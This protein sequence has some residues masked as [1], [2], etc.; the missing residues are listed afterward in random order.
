[1][2][3]AGVTMRTFG[4]ETH[5]GPHERRPHPTGR[6]PCMVA[7]E[8]DRTA[9]WHLGA[10]SLLREVTREHVIER[11]DDFSDIEAR[12]G[13]LPT[14]SDRAL[15]PYVPAIEHARYLHEMAKVAIRVD[16][17]HWL[18]AFL[19]RDGRQLE[20]QVLATE[21]QQA[22]VVQMRRLA[23]RVDRQGADTVVFTN[24]A[25]LAPMITNS[26]Y[27]RAGLRAGEREDRREALFTY[28]LQRGEE[29]LMLLTPVSRDDD[30]G[31]VLGE[32]EE[33]AFQGSSIFGP[34]LR[35]WAAW[36]TSASSPRS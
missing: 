33:T 7:T 13:A 19:Y 23:A 10:A 6:L 27:P 9:Y 2:S 16:G 31:V 29:P 11:D 22:K 35:V 17:I 25:W 34:V 5:G 28:L 14:T 3:V 24:E 15:H 18:I 4:G 8:K 20:M 21:D 26:G 12:Y 30:G 1:M 36:E 32:T